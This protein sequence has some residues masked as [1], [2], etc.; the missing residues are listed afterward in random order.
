MANIG[1]K[2]DSS[3][4]PVLTT[5]ASLEI[6]ELSDTEEEAGAREDCEQRLA[7]LQCLRSWQPQKKATAPS[8]SSMYIKHTNS[9]GSESDLTP[10]SNDFVKVDSFEI[11]EVQKAGWNS[12][13]ANQTVK[14]LHQE[15]KKRE[16]DA[17]LE[18]QSLQSRTEREV[19]TLIRELEVA[20]QE[21]RII[22]DQCSQLREQL[23]LS[24]DALSRRTEKG[25]EALQAYYTQQEDYYKG[26]QRNFTDV[27]DDIPKRS[28]EQDTQEEVASLQSG[29]A[30]LV[31]GIERLRVA[32][33]PSRNE[34]TLSSGPLLSSSANEDKRE[35]NVRKMY[36]KTKRQ[37]DILR[38]VAND[39][40]T[41][42]RSMDLS[43]FGEFGKY[44]R[45]LRA[46]LNPEE[47]GGHDGQALNVRKV[48]EDRE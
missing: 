37:Y 31:A 12:Q 13:A 33:R 29:K 19:A 25:D 28:A 39:V 16:A 1:K 14:K 3:G 18:M 38:S 6:I 24:Q 46:S 10:K 45:K 8:V 30:Q 27:L 48:F 17:L 35:D 15:M 21:T 42:T 7:M 5:S 34:S 2:V 44:M 32:T 4:S 40:A 9:P 36:I 43:S 22:A 47:D 23:Q 11:E 41:C 20:K 26:D